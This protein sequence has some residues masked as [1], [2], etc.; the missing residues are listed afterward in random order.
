MKMKPKYRLNIKGYSDNAAKKFPIT[1]LITFTV[2]SLVLFVLLLV[3]TI[4][5]NYKGKAL[6][7]CV[8]ALILI[9]GY[10]ILNITALIKKANTKK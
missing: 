2:I 7:F 3:T 6:F 4:Q 8:V 5:S 10:F 9:F 1:K